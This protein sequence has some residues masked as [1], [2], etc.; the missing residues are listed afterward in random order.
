MMGT[1]PEYI[2]WLLQECDYPHSVMDVGLIQTHISH[3]IVAG[4]FVYKFKKPMN[5][6]FLDFSSLEK[7]KFYCEQELSLNRRLCPEIYVDLVA[8]TR[9]KQSF[10][11][12]GSGE[13]VE[14]GVKMVRMPENRMMN[15]V[16]E[17]SELEK[18]E[19]DRII[20]K[21][22]P[23][24]QGVERDERIKDFGH[25]Q[26]VAVNVLENF[27][28]TEVFINKG[29]LQHCQFEE[30]KAYCSKIL[31]NEALFN[32]RIAEGKI[33]DCHGDLHSANICLAEKVYIFDCIEF[34]DRLR[35]SDVVADIAFLAMDLDYHGLERLSSYFT[36]SFMQ[37]S[38]DDSMYEVLNFYKCYRAYVRGKIALLTMN[39]PVVDI[40]TKKR[41]SE[42][43]IRYFALAASYCK[44]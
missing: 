6:S 27:H 30:I 11:L 10:Q 14:Y 44:T 13:I 25:A 5:F 35:Y 4:G 39:D 38:G 41:C 29:V 31:R 26:A 33:H 42:K 9:D 2:T 22:I 3:I 24:Y 19:I 12:N 18:E 23:F 15:R 28:Q 7:R 34:N 1:I 21:L 20:A 37:S 16:M 8:V 32:K 17:T 43:A 36:D 40:P